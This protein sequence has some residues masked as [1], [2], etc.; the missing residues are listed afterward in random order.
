MEYGGGDGI[1]SVNHFQAE[2]RGPMQTMKFLRL[3]FFS[4]KI[5][6]A[7]SPELGKRNIPE[8]TGTLSAGHG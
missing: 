7:G 5:L 6:D 2:W 8:I 4:I 3:N 1:S